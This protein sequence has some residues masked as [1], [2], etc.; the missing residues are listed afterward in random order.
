MMQAALEALVRRTVDGA[1]PGLAD[2][3]SG[4]KS[5]QVW[6]G[7]WDTLASPQRLTVQT[8]AAL[9]SLIDL[10]VIDV[11]RTV[12]TRGPLTVRGSGGNVVT[13]PPSPREAETVVRPTCRV[14]I[15]VTLISSQPGAAARAEGVLELAEQALPVMV[16]HA[17]ENIEGTNLE[18][19]ALRKRGMSAFLLL[20]RRE[21]E[22]APADPARVLPGRVDVRG[23]TVTRTIYPEPDC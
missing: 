18:S 11:G 19:D 4:L 6:E 9:V 8:P 7:A 3:V 1:P 22:L 15:A 16:A 14:E 5:V 20:G 21:L 13:I 2:A 17:L 23:S 12:Q 10:A